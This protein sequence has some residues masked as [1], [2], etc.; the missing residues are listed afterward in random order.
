VDIFWLRDESLEDS[1]NLRDSGF[2]REI[3]E[4][5]EAAFEQFR[6]MD[7]ASVAQ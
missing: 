5:I 1:E 4:D 6:K 2:S 7:D 3:V